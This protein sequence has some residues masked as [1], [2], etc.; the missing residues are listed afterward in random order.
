MDVDPITTN[1]PTNADLARGFN[2]LHK[3]HEDTK[4][5]VVEIQHALGIV[6]GGKPVAGLSSPWKAFLR[7]TGATATAITGL[8]LLWRIGATLAPDVWS[9]LVHLNAAI[10][11]KKF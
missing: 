9:L 5:K 6:P 1:K 3:C 10:I 11:G 8:V 2:Q 4:D 7:T